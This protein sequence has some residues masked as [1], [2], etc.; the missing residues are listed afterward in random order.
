MGARS[1][2]L[3]ESRGKVAQHRRLGADPV[4][5]EPVSVLEYL[6]HRFDDIVDMALRVDT[7]WNR[8]PHQLHGGRDKPAG[9]GLHATKHHAPDFHRADPGHAVKLADD[10]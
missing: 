4:S 7:P 10:P 3:R 5:P 6:D 1:V 9:G 2:E 8:E